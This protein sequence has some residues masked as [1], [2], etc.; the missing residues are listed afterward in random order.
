MAR[1]E[2]AFY[3]GCS[4]Q[5]GSS[6]SN[7]LTSVMS[8]C[9]TLDI[10][11]TEIP[12]WNCCGASISYAE[13]GELPRH[14]MNARNFA[15]AEQHLPG[16]E[17]VATCA[18]CWLG[19][20]ETKERLEHNA[21]LMADTLEALKEAGLTLKEIP[22][23][24]HMVEVLIEDLGYEELKKPVKKPLEGMKFAGYVGC[25]TN[26]PF[27]IHGESFENP[28]YLDKLIETVGGEAVPYDQKVTCCGGALAFSEPEKAQAQIKDIIESAYD[29]GAEMLVTPCPLCQ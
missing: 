17:I 6:A 10:K 3:P 23:I 14:A 9:K 1:K 5:K 15:L 29:N 16:Q 27:G 26:R 18:A 25:Q 2:Y 12:D 21:S 24:R 22:P 19:A 13:S 20:R 28:V 7:Y 8:M 11:I 4:S